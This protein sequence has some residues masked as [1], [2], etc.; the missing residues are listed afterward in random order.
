V[1]LA[2]LDVQFSEAVAQ[3]TEPLRCGDIRYVEA[4]AREVKGATGMSELLQGARFAGRDHDT[5]TMAA[6]KD[7][8]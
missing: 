7:S 4:A 5:R 1:G 6:A 8:V 3:S 2:D